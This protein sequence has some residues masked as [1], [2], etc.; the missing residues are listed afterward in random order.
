M[1]LYPI[2][3]KKDM[4]VY[5]FVVDNGAPFALLFPGGRYGDVCSLVEG[6]STALKLN[7]FGYNTFI[8]N[9]TIGKMTHPTEPIDD[10][11]AALAYIFDHCKEW[12]A[13]NRC[14]L[15]GFSAGGHLAATWG[16][17][18]PGL[19]KSRIQKA[20][21]RDSLL[22]AHH[23]GGIRPCWQSQESIGQSRLRERSSRCLFD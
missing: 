18:N 3:K 15:C 6:Y 23:D 19:S 22:P 20:R 12:K 1:F 4:G 13:A 16:T 17:E 14:A 8:V 5:V 11:P 9:Y 2:Q 10:V 7:D 21:S